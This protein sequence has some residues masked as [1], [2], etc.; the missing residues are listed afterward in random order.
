M[1]GSTKT[2]DCRGVPVCTSSTL[3]VG[4]KPVVSTVTEQSMPGPDRPV[5]GPDMGHGEGKRAGTVPREL[6]L[7]LR[8]LWKLDCVSLLTFMSVS[9]PSSFDVNC[10]P[11]PS[12]APPARA[13][14]S[15][16]RTWRGVSLRAPYAMSGTDITSCSRQTW[17]PQRYLSL[18]MRL[19]S[20]SSEALRLS[21]SRFASCFL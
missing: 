14:A 15:P 17:A 1:S 3:Y 13:A 16:L 21:S 2:P 8:K 18:V 12:S 19:R 6:S 11:P 9:I 5:S 20:S 7:L 10:S 4:Q